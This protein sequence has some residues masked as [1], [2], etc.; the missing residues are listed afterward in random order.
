MHDVAIHE[1]FTAATFQIIHTI[2]ITHQQFKLKIFIYQL[3][4]NLFLPTNRKQAKRMKQEANKKLIEMLRN[5]DH[6]KRNLLA[7][8]YHQK[9]YKLIGIDLWSQTN[10]SNPQKVNFI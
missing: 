6:T 2:S 10:T 1:V 5:N 4:I 3:A 9:C 7:C 8:L